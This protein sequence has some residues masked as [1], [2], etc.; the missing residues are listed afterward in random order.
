MLVGL[1]LWLDFHDPQCG[2]DPNQGGAEQGHPRVNELSKWD[3]ISKITSL[4][5][6]SN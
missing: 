1:Q 6:V 4:P 2:H 5:L 3:Q